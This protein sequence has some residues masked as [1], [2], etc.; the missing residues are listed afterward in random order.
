MSDDDEVMTEEQLNAA[1]RQQIE[2][3]GAALEAFMLTL[4]ANGFDDGTALRAGYA[5]VELVEKG[6]REV[7]GRAGMPE[8][9]TQ[10]ILEMQQRNGRKLGSMYY[11]RR[12]VAIDSSQVPGVG[13]QIAAMAPGEEA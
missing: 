10:A 4:Q 1:T 9:E 2:S 7:R 12:V 3:T 6:N 5:L 11:D 8:D 13:F